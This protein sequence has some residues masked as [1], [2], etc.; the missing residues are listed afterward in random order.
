MSSSPQRLVR[1]ALLVLGVSLALAGACYEAPRQDGYYRCSDD[2]E[3][4]NGGLVCD[5]GVCCSERGTPLCLG[6]VLD[7]GTCADGGTA[8]RYFQ[9]LD[10]DGFGNLTQPI[11]RCAVPESFRAVTNSDDCND[12]PAAGGRLFFPGAPEQC[13]GLDNDCDGQFDEGF[14]GVTYYRDEDNDGYG[15][16]QQQRVL[17]QPSA[18]YVAAPDDCQPLNPRVH[19]NADEVCNYTDDDCN[20]VADEGVKLTWY[21]DGDHDGF[22]RPDMKILDCLQPDS[23]VANNT[24]CNDTNPLIYP[25]ALDRCDGVNNDCGD[26]QVDER[27]DCGGPSNLLDLAS[28]RDRGAVN[29][30]HSFS[31][32]TD[33]CVRDWDGGVPESFSA[34]NVWSGSRP[35]SHIVWFE[36]TNAWDLTRAD[37]GLVIDFDPTMSGNG[38]PSW[39]PHKQP[40][41]LL[42]SDSGY[43]RYVP[44][45]DGGTTPLMPTAGGRVTAVLPIGQG[46]GAGWVERSSNLDLRHVRR[47]EIMV[48]PSDAG[49]PTVS[50]DI[51]FLKLGFQ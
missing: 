43:A 22:G 17:C 2:A 45:F 48:E 24:D 3:C 32:V 34:N 12:N 6:R 4:G 31:G 40:I 37:G 26:T 47:I 33:G 36:A 5:D 9:D 42:C 8:T 50:F 16:T 28:T 46:G 30:R 21:R 25:G 35:Q 10:E 41:V 20:G 1:L 23:G 14:P 7:G 18:G 51:Q 11:D 29:T 27:P 19:P 44:V 15:D 13:D 38:I 49:T 39:A